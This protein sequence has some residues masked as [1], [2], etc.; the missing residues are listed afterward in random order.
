M[1]E[2]EPYNQ[3]RHEH[4]R[5]GTDQPRQAEEHADKSCHRE[6]VAP[7]QRRQECRHEHHPHFV[8]LGHPGKLPHWWKQCDQR[9]DR[10]CCVGIWD[11]AI[12]KKEKRQHEPGAGQSRDQ[13]SRGW[14]VQAE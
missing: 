5:R 1:R 9:R 12:Q 13:E 7:H 6:L 11:V 14:R 8:G 3:G 2:Q 4:D 10:E